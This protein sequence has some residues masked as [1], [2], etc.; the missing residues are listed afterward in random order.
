KNAKGS[1]EIIEF[2]TSAE[3]QKP[4][5]DKGQDVPANLEL[6]ESD[7]FLDPDW[8]EADINLQ[9][10]P[11][12]AERNFTPKF[13]PE[14]NEIQ[15]AIE[16]A[17]AAFWLGEADAQSTAHDLQG[18][19]ERAIKPSERS[20]DDCHHRRPARLAPG[21]PRRTPAPLPPVDARAS[22]ARVAHLLSVRLAVGELLRGLPAGPYA[23]LH[24]PLLHPVGLVHRPGLGGAGQLHHPVHR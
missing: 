24:L 15:K 6:Q 17:M 7:D 22:P 4:I 1:F 21:A 20:A 2:L 9:A 13:I 8:L 16:D 12:S 18:R 10:F 19:L 14:W 11:D 3:G 5:A 23:V